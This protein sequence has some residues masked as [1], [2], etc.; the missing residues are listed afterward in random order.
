MP[1]RSRGKPVRQWFNKRVETVYA[2]L[3]DRGLPPDLY[4]D[5]D[6][7][8]R[9][10][11]DDLEAYP[12]TDANGYEKL[13]YGETGY[14]V[15]RR[16]PQTHTLHP[17]SSILINLPE[18]ET[19][20]TT[21]QGTVPNE[22]AITAITS[23]L[24]EECHPTVRR[25][26]RVTLYPLGLM[27]TVGN[28]QANAAFPPF[29]DRLECLNAKLVGDQDASD[30]EEDEEHPKQRRVFPL[31]AV[32][33]QGYNVISHRVRPS[34]AF[35]EAQLGLCGGA[36]AGTYAMTPRG[37]GTAQRLALLNEDTLPH[38]RFQHLVA[39]QNNT[40]RDVRLE[41]ILVLNIDGL[42]PR[43]RRGR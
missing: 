25:K 37:K 36:A 7:A 5:S 28:V 43:D 12:M 34:A 41:T 6:P 10:H 11:I 20:F 17:E 24:A 21:G 2:A 40:P 13:V 32:S 4:D 14:H 29:A 18:F 8:I 9:L 26:K 33:M 30:E 38:D 23:Q 31:E 27:K 1:A 16:M 39:N 3:E 15:E 42:R 19:I 35:H 22:H